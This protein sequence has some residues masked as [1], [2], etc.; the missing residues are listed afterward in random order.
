MGE[1]E[2]ALADAVEVAY[3]R[4]NALITVDRD[5]EAAL[6]ALA[7]LRGP[8]DAFVETVLGMDP[9]P[10]LRTNRLALLNRLRGLF[11]DFADFGELAG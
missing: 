2:A 7:D 4:V 10:A 9:D 3:E 1:E 11:V 6:S 8:V 5:Y